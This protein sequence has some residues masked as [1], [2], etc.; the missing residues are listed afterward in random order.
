MLI[1]RLTKTPE[2]R[3]TPK[4]KQVCS[5]TIATNRINNEECDFINCV[6]WDK[7]A[8]NLCKYQV[9]GCLIAILGQLRVDRYEVSGVKKTKAYVHVNEIEYLT[10]NKQESK[11]IDPY[12]DFGN[13]IK[14]E[15]NIGE[16]I[17][18][19]ESDYPF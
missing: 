4:G 12:K 11:E 3:T 6:V 15:S 10:I 9:K 1:G 18:I 7:Q 13:S 8:E 19:E 14:T 5:F 2:L 17:Q 16:Q